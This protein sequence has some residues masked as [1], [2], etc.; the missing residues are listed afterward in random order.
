MPADHVTEHSYSLNVKCLSQTPAFEHLV[1]A[2]ST[3]LTSLQSGWPSCVVKEGAG[4]E[5]PTSSPLPR[6]SVFWL[7]VTQDVNCHLAFLPL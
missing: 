2:E 5:G 7:A 3:I 4:P 1:R 6:V